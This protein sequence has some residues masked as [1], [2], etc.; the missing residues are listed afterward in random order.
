MSR[1]RYEGSALADRPSP[2]AG[3]MRNIEVIG[4]EPRLLAAIYAAPFGRRKVGSMWNL[5]HHLATTGSTGGDNMPPRT[6]WDVRT[7]NETP[8][9]TVIHV[10][11]SAESETA[12]D[13][14]RTSRPAPLKREFTGRRSSVPKT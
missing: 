7:V 8:F 2:A 12:V 9:D 14:W 10:V 5:D 4:S 3:C 13:G 6:V 11:E 1:T